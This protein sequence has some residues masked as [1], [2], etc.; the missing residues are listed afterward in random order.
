MTEKYQVLRPLNPAEYES[1]KESIRVNGVLTPL[2]SDE[3]GNI[4]N[5][6]HRRRIFDELRAEGIAIA[7]PPT[8][9]MVGLTE[10]QKITLAYELNI[11]GRQLSADELAE[12]RSR[13]GRRKA[14]EQSLKQSPQMADNWHAQQTGVSDKTIRTVRNEME[15]TSEIPKLD[16]LVG[17][18]GKERPRQVERKSVSSDQDSNP[19]PCDLCKAAHP[20]CMACCAKCEDRCNTQQTCRL[21]QVAEVLT[22][23]KWDN[24]LPPPITI[25][26]KPITIFEPTESKI[27]CAK[28]LLQKAT[29]ELVDAV[30]TGKVPLLQ[31]TAVASAATTSEQ[32]EA[33]KRL[34]AGQAAYLMDGVNQQRM[35]AYCPNTPDQRREVEERIREGDKRIDREYKL[36]S[37]IDK[38]VAAVLS[39][40]SE[41][42]DESVRYWLEH[43]RA[44]EDKEEMIDDLARCIERLQMLKLA[45]SRTKTLK[46]VK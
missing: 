2:V 44:P 32:K 12:M 39:L 13:A 9:V 43:Q 22:E 21:P 7:E 23:T 17:A 5:G 29:P 36:S 37:Q 38:I 20:C 1:L 24:P 26:S 11:T 46:V 45:F 33:I 3:N 28:E 31:G 6:H 19:T 34:D 18:D 40:R 10:E 27:E 35:E 4:I 30:A 25:A 14:A 8:A 41:E 16:K 42:I 15:S